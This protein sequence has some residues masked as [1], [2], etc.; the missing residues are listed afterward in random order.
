M[1][2]EIICNECGDIFSIPIILGKRGRKR[3]FCKAC[4]EDKQ[5]TSKKYYRPLHDWVDYMAK[6][7]R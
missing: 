3:I 6:R 4:L 5:H 2:Q 1:K 7:Y